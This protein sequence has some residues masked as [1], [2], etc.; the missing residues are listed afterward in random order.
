M[1]NLFR[2][3]ITENDLIEVETSIAGIIYY[4]DFKLG[5][6]SIRLT[7]RFEIQYNEKLEEGRYSEPFN[8][9]AL[10]A[11]LRPQ[12]RYWDGDAWVATPTITKYWSARQ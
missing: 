10:A 9:D 4:F 11:K 3:E 2:I 12:I 1:D 5:L 7:N 6:E 8:H